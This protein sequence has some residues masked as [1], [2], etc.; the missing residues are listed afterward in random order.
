M[1]HVCSTRGTQ[2]HEGNPALPV[3]A[4]CFPGRE[5]V[6]HV[7]GHQRRRNS[8][9]SMHT[10]DHPSLPTL[11]SLS[12]RWRINDLRANLALLRR[13]LVYFLLPTF[14]TRMP[15]I[16]Y[17]PTLQTRLSQYLNLYKEKANNQDNY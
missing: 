15:F 3:A 14:F 7:I 11:L 8:L 10:R 12:I 16:V 17:S 13:A 5:D 6:R 1:S 2:V 9:V 4:C